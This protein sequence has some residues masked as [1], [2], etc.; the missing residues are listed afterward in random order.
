MLVAADHHL[1]LRSADLDN[2]QRGSGG[3]TEPL[4]LANG[5]VMNAGMLADDFSVRSDK[6]P[7]GI[8][9]RLSLFCQVS[10]DET[11]I[12]SAR[13]KADLLRIRLLRQRQTMPARKLTH[14]RLRHIAQGK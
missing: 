4:A 12:V 6:F 10:I 2:V 1:L 11:L 7:G 14:L 9:K 13:D 3:D 8:G 5:E